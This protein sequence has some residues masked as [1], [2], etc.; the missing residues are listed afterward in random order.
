MKSL[1]FQSRPYRHHPAVRMMVSS[2]VLIVSIVLFKA[3]ITKPLFKTMF[4]QEWIAKSLVAIFSTGW[5]V[6]IYHLLS[7]YY[8]K[9]P[10]IEFSGKFAFRSLIIG[11]FTGFFGHWPGRI[12]PLCM[13]L[14]R[15]DRNQVFYSLPLHGVFY[16]GCSDAGRTHFSGYSLSGYRGLERHSGC[17]DHFFFDLPVAAFHESARRM[18]TCYFRCFIWS[19]HRIDVHDNEK[20]M[21]AICLSLWLEPGPTHTGHDTIGHQYI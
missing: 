13:G 20:V 11:F 7:R 14:L 19:G 10:V 16:H 3:L 2:I 17:I 1:Y 9:R 21:V 6:L 4:A 12:D 5:M 15:S 18:A 8:E